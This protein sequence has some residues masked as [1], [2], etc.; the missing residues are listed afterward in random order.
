[1]HPQGFFRLMPEGAWHS[2][3]AYISFGETGSRYFKKQY[4]SGVR[5][6]S[7]SGFFQ[8]SI[9]PGKIIQMSGVEAERKN[10]KS[11]AHCH[12]CPKDDLID[13]A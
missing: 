11:N 13:E 6:H 9:V 5:F 10:K 3:F 12:Y 7:N 2:N 8:N 4:G 1:M